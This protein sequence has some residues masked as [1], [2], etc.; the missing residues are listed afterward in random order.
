MILRCETIVPK[1]KLSGAKEVAAGLFFEAVFGTSGASRGLNVL[2]SISAF[3]NLITT[4]I[5]QSRVIRECGRYAQDYAYIN[6][7]IYIYEYPILRHSNLLLSCRQGV[8]PWPRFWASTYP[9]GTPLGPYFVKWAVTIV[10]IL[11]PPAGDAFNF[12]MSQPHLYLSIYLSIHVYISICYIITLFEL[13]PCKTAVDLQTYPNSV[14]YFCMT[15]GLLLI[16]RQ[17]KRIGAPKS[18]FRAWDAAV[19]LTLAVY[20]FLLAMPWYPPSGGQYAGDV[21]FWYATYCV[22]GIAM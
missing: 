2:I 1:Q 3:G 19:G 17:R 16:R 5:G 11:A 15:A 9:F 22:V 18:E 14:F 8:L 6:I 12:G 7:N 13:T 20:I 21:S 4:L 10:M